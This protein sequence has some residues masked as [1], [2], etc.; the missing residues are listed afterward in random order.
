MFRLKLDLRHQP[1]ER[2]LRGISNAV[3]IK[4][5]A[6]DCLARS[7]QLPGLGIQPRHLALQ[8]LCGTVAFAKVVQPRHFPHHRLKLVIGIL[9]QRTARL[10]VSSGHKRCTQS[11]I[12]MGQIKMR[13][14]RKILCQRDQQIFGCRWR[15]G[16]AVGQTK[17]RIRFPVSRRL[18]AAR[19]NTG[20]EE[21]VNP[22][23]VK[24]QGR[25]KPT[26]S[27]RAYIAFAFFDIRKKR[28]AAG[29]LHDAAQFV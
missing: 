4:L 19:G 22:F 17:K 14:L 12:S 25:Y 11:V 15:G 21:D 5:Q 29:A 18:F 7:F 27:P 6:K 23:L 28:F 3:L 26:C 8:C 1:L 16:I 13:S 10:D 24:V 2:V 20:V 9:R